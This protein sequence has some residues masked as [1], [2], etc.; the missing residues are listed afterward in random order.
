[1][2]HPPRLFERLL[3]LT[4]PAAVS[5][6]IAGDLEEAFYVKARTGNRFTAS[7]WYRRQ[8]MSVWFGYLFEG[9]SSPDPETRS[10]S[11][12]RLTGNE[13]LVT[14]YGKRGTV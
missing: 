13:S 3:T 14:G 10:G 12:Y 5:E 9:L 6:A 11:G 8:V 1:M 2:I 7:W 4:L